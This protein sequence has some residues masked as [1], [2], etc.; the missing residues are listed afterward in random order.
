VVWQIAIDQRPDKVRA[1]WIRSDGSAGKPTDVSPS[2]TSVLMSGAVVGPRGDAIVAWTGGLP[3]ELHARR[4]RPDRRVSPIF[5]LARVTA[6]P[7]KIAGYDNG[8]AVMA[9]LRLSEFHVREFAADGTAGATLRVAT[10]TD[11]S[12]TELLDLVAGGRFAYFAWTVLDE[13]AHEGAFIPR[14]IR[15]RSL[16]RSGGL[17]PVETVWRP[18]TLGDVSLGRQRVAANARGGA[19]VSWTSVSYSADPTAEGS[20][21]TYL[22]AS[23][24]RDRARAR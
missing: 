7:A 9:W 16:D 22:H 14:A 13:N 2:G 18:G 21:P 3:N 6:G 4:V 5:T 17:S 1:A 20:Q 10:V 24:L 8:D 11:F 19:V 12:G 23:F 15:V